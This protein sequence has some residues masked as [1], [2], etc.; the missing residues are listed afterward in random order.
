[1]IEDVSGTLHGWIWRSNLLPFLKMTSD[2]VRYSFGSE[3][4]D[5]VLTGLADTDPEAS[6]W[7][8]Y[9]LA[10]ELP[11]TLGLSG[12]EDVVLIDIDLD[13]LTERFVTQIGVLLDVFSVYRVSEQPGL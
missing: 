1:M 6:R 13:G 4:E 7:F 5:A 2:F 8:D 12:G 3:D 11:V 9:Q 10:G